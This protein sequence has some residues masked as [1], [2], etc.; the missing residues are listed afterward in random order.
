MRQK[1]DKVAFLTAVVLLASLAG[2]ASQAG[3][4]EG[5]KATLPADDGSPG[6]LDRIASQ[7]TVSEN[8]ACRGVLM[9]LNAEDQAA[10]FEKR[11]EKLLARGILPG[12]GGHDAAKPIRRGKLAYMICQACKIRGGVILSL[13]GPSERYCHRELQYLQMMS[14]GS[15]FGRVSGMEFVAV[16]SRADVY[17]RT[18]KLPVIMEAIGGGR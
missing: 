7:A 13:T 12:A 11:V 15:Q 14:G 2:C 3:K 8:D 6:F 18:G 10:A 4:I 17:V 1:R 5:A 9:L 16:L